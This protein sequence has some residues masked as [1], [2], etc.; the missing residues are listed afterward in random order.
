MAANV[1]DGTMTSA[2]AGSSSARI[3]SMSPAVQDDMATASAAPVRRQ[4]SC[5]KARTTDPVV[6]IPSSQPGRTSSSNSRKVGRV[7]R[8][9]GITCMF[10]PP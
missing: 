4:T 3:A 8:M 7:G 10:G 9:I 2:P 1:N 5:S 6:T